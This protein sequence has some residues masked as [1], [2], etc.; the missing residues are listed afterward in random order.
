M[1]NTP[2]TLFNRALKATEIVASLAKLEGWCLSGDGS[3]VAIEKA[4]FFTDYAQT[5]AF[6]NAV[7]WSAQANHHHPEL[8]VQFGRC[9]VRLHTHDVAG[10]SQAD[11]DSATRVDA[12]IDANKTLG[13]RPRT[14]GLMHPA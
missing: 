8:L 5:M 10:L 11:F 12:L 2:G 3:D 7:A 9:V 4:F 14:N 13:T 6:V 1:T